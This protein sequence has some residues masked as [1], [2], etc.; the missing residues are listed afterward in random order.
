MSYWY[1]VIYKWDLWVSNRKMFMIIKNNDFCVDQRDH[2]SHISCQIPC[3]IVL[4]SKWLNES[5]TQTTENPPTPATTVILYWYGRCHFFSVL[6]W[7]RSRPEKILIYTVLQLD[8][9]TGLLFGQWGDLIEAE[10]WV[11][12]DGVAVRHYSRMINDNFLLVQGV[13]R[14]RMRT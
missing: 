3:T 1:N 9:Q 4:E 14:D 6:N 7:R 5:R 10:V 12:T 8:K 13:K 11:L 2:K